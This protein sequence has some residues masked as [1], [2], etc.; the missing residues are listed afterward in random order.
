MLK[1]LRIASTL[2]CTLQGSGAW[3]GEGH[4]SHPEDIALMATIAKGQLRRDGKPYADGSS[5]V[6]L[7]DDE[8][9]ALYPY[10]ELAMI[11]AADNIGNGYSRDPYALGEYNAAR[12][13]LPKLE[14]PRPASLSAPATV[15]KK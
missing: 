15:E 6:E 9:A 1:K 4:H 2:I 14:P 3:H 7:D 12:A 11:G 13:L 5:H 10:I 8:R